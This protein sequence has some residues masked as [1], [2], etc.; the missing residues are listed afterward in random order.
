MPTFEVIINETMIHGYIVDAKDADEAED[1]AMRRYEDGKA[2]E[3]DGQ[4]ASDTEVA[5]VNKIT[6]EES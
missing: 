4:Y 6:A 5:A 1:L 3:M 2:G